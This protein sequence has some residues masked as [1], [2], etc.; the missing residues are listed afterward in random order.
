M[1]DFGKFDTHAH[2]WALD[3][4]RY[5]WDPVLPGVDI[6]VTAASPESLLAAMAE[7]GVGRC[8]LVQPSTYGWDNGFLAE[9]LR[10]YPAQFVGVALVNPIDRTATDRLRE[11]GRVPGMRGV[12]FHLL[13]A[14]GGR[15]V[16]GGAVSLMEAV[17]EAG[18]RVVLQVRPELFPAAERLLEESRGVPVV[19]DHMG[20]V[21][22]GH[23]E[24]LRDLL[25]LARFENLYVKLS[26]AEEISGEAFPFWDCRPVATAIVSEFGVGRVMWGSNSPHSLAK[27]SYSEVATVWHRWLGEMS[28][29][30]LAD[31]GGGCAERVWG[32]PDGQGEKEKAGRGREMP[33]E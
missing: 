6:P 4:G 15:W 30:E 29:Q 18:L 5:P 26:G 19:I 20:L 16:E 33:R 2:V 32:G 14:E 28:E 7:A 3:E 25:T 27:C 12:R 23:R 17:E 1:V 10:R 9:V 22:P 31:I 8:V 21:P 13:N 11:L 24:A